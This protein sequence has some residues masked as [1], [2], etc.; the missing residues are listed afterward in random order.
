MQGLGLSN[1]VDRFQQGVAWSQQQEE[2]GRVRAQRQAMDEANRTATSVLDEDKAQWA[3]Q[4]A[5]GT[6]KPN[7]STMFRAAEARGMALA[8]AGLWDHFV[9]NEAQVAPMRMRARAAAVQDFDLT[10][11]PDKFMRSVYPTLFD[12]R[13]I[14]S[15]ER[16][17][18]ADAVQGLP[19]IANKMVFT[20]DDGTKQSFSDADIKRIYG[21]TK[22]SL[23]D[24]VESA[25]REAMINQKRAEAEI[26][27]AKQQ[28]IETTKQAGRVQLEGV[29]NSYAITQEG[30]KQSN[31]LGLADVNN[32]SAERRSAGNN[33]ATLQAAG[34]AANSRLQAANV[35]AD[36]RKYAADKPEKAAKAP[37]FK[38]LHDQVTR[39]MGMPQQGLM[40]GNKVSDEH[41][42]Q[43]ANFA[44]ALLKKNP[45]MNEGEAVSLA[46][47]EWKK[48]GNKRPVPFGQQLQ[49]A[50]VPTE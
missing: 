1:A 43:V 31:R 37:N 30:L 19:A 44:Q 39:V 17:Q 50:G 41:T 29:K 13:R 38:E 5:P 9:Q 4:G 24:P 3:L 7:D 27:A 32:A 48:R 49:D 22:A 21:Q 35:S 23:V 36:A 11:D 34:V 40:G 18:G 45:G 28:A 47:T 20:L 26:E 42:M 16:I 46:V 12:G 15:S 8:K 25:K 14:V 10:G 6:Y 2:I 33:A